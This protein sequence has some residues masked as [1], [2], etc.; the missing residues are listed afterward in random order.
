MV[1]CLCPYQAVHVEELQR[2]QALVTEA[3]TSLDSYKQQLEKFDQERADLKCKVKEQKTRF[4]F[5]QQ[6]LERAEVLFL[7]E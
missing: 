1:L 2:L 3:H 7:T 6:K 4:D 5:T